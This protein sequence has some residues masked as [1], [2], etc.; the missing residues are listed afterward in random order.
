MNYRVVFDSAASAELS[1]L[2][3]LARYEL[4]GHG[5]HTIVGSDTSGTDAKSLSSDGYPCTWS[6]PCPMTIVGHDPYLPFGA[7]AAVGLVVGLAVGL[8]LGVLM[9]KSFKSGAGPG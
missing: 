7:G 2:F 1:K 6:H 3:W 5:L 9:R 8:S 4:S